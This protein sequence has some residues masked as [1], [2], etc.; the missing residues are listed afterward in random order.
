MLIGN[1]QIIAGRTLSVLVGSSVQSQVHS[2]WYLGV[3]IEIYDF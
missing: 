3:L 2:F 1:R